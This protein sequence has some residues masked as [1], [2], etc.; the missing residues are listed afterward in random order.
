M[1]A[2]WQAVVLLSSVALA[3]MPCEGPQAPIFCYGP[4]LKA[5]QEL[6]IFNGESDCAICSP[7]DSKYFVDMPLAFDADVVINASSALLQNFT[8]YSILLLDLL[9]SRDHA[10]A[11]LDTYFLNA[12]AS[13]RSWEPSD[14]DPS[15]DVVR[16]LS[17]SPLSRAPA[18]GRLHYYLLV[19]F[20]FLNSRSLLRTCSCKISSVSDPL[21]KEF[22]QSLNDRWL[23]LGQQ[24]FIPCLPPCRC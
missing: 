24:V 12:S 23:Q 14:W 8:R 21:L 11:F 1:Q 10:V 3:F 16:F 7:R 5:F 9:R 4:I 17:F 19:V 13:V 20:A 18:H 6:N 15:P 22:T 2:I